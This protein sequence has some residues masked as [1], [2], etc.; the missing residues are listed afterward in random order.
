MA[1]EMLAIKIRS[2]KNI[3]G[4]EIWGIKTKV[5]MY[6]DDSSFS[7]YPQSGSL[8][9]LLEDHGH[10]S[11]LSGLNHNY[12]KCTVLHIASLKNTVFTLP[13]SLPIQFEDGEVDIPGTYLHLK[14][15]K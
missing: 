2:N 15:Y 8:H 11:S 1:I 10:F 3:K 14:K 13:C 7:L 4:L 5:S 6:G 9:S 12:D